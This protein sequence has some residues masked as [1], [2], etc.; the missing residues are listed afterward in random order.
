MLPLVAMYESQ[1]IPK[2]I[3]TNYFAPTKTYI[4][5]KTRKIIESNQ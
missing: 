2:G 5:Y 1:M 4:Q 3:K